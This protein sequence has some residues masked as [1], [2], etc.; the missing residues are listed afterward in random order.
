[1]Y[2]LQ[3][4]VRSAADRTCWQF[5]R[6][7]ARWRLWEKTA[8]LVCMMAGFPFASYDYKLVHLITPLLL[9][10]RENHYS[11][12]AH[13]VACL[14]AL[15]LV[16]KGYTRI[17]FLA[18]P[19]SLVNPLLLVAIMLVLMWPEAREFGPKPSASLVNSAGPFHEGR[20]A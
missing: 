17:F 11:A 12:R 16:P 18:T 13:I 6:N 5:Y 4:G 20:T 8:L 19:G 7:D 3:E 15:V 14:I 1:M 10:L 9:Y 2:V